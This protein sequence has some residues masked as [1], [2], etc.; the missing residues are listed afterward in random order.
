MRFA[1]HALLLALCLSAPGLAAAK[2]KP[3]PVQCPADVLVAMAATCPCDGVVQP[4]T[5]VVPWRNH[6]QYMRCVVHQRNAYRKAGCLDDTLKRTIARCAARS[7]CGK[8]GRVL[9]CTYDLGTCS[10][11]TPGDATP[12]G[13]CSNDAA[14]VCDV[15]ADCTKSDATLARDGAACAERGGVDVGSGSVCTACPPPPAE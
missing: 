9:C 14:V 15:D 8:E 7:T 10:D 13:T 5:T 2:G 3:E 12:A 1:A 6:G 4:D 11:V